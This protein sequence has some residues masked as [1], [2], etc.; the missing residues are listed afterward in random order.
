MTEPI[1]ISIPSSI[2]TPRL[3]LR[4]FRVDDA[5]Q[6]HNALVES[7]NELR[8]NLWFL[9][10]VAEEQ[11][12]QSAEIRCLQAKENFALRTDLPYLAIEKNTGRIVASIGLHRTNLTMRKT[13]VGYWVR[14]SATGKGF[15][16]EGVNAI[17]NR[18]LA[19]P[20]IR[21][22][23]LITDEQNLRSRAV[24]QRCGFTLEEINYNAEQAPDGSLRNNCI[25]IKESQA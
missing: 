14:S 16:T 15:A 22:V 6:L 2:D 20:G 7:I 21:R 1:H 13:E 9:P 25:Y 4:S 17:T 18:A 3:I 11:T 10:W 19:E 23:E 24:A 12:L 8:K 5:P